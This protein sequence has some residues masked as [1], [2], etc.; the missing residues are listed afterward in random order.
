MSGAC[1]RHLQRRNGIYHLRL[2]LPNAVRQI[3]GLSMV[4]KSLRTYSHR[5]ARRQ[6]AILPVRR[7]EAF[8]MILDN[9]LDKE[10]GLG[11]SVPVLLN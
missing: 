1:S 10:R 3:V 8:A 9:Q 6:A 4:R 7:G 5:D 2:R 11:L